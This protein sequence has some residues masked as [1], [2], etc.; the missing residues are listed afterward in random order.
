MMARGRSVGSTLNM[1]DALEADDARE[2]LRETFF[3]TVAPPAPAPTRAARGRR[4]RATRREHYKVICVSLYNEDLERLDAAVREL[5][6]RG[7]SRA[8]RSAV[9]RAAM[10]QMDLDRVRRAL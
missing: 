2:I 7:N 8:N 10:Q 5:K 3:T 4:A 9:L 6:R 1:Q